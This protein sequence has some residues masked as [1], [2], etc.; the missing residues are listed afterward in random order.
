M[1]TPFPKDPEPKLLEVYHNDPIVNSC[2][3]MGVSMEEIIVYMAKRHKD[4]LEEM[5][6]KDLDRTHYA[7]IETPLNAE[8]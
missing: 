8:A 7:I 4:V 2:V 3:R 5:F 6:K 1:S